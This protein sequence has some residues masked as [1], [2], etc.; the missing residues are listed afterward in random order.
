MPSPM[1]R[2]L[3]SFTVLGCAALA[4][5][6]LAVTPVGATTRPAPARAPAD[7]SPAAGDQSLR[8]F[9]P[10]GGDAGWA[11]TEDLNGAPQG[12]ART[13]NGGK[14][15]QKVTPNGLGK[16]TGD[17]VITGFFALG[18]EHAWVTYGG[19]SNGA[20][21]HIAA[22]TDGG[23]HW[24]V[25]GQ[26]PLTS[27]SYSGYVYDCGLDFVSASVGW[28]Q[29][30]PA[31]VGSEGVALY[32]TTDGGRHWKL[33]SQTGPNGNKAG[34]L[35]WSCDKEIQFSSTTT[36]WAIFGCPNAAP[37]YETT[38][39]G[40]T[41]IKRKVAAPGGTVD[42]GSG[43]TGQPLVSGSRGAVGFTISGQPLKTLVYVTSDGGKSWRPVTPPGASEG[44]VADAITPQSWRLVDG[45]HILATDN[46]GKTWRTITSNVTFDI[47]YAFDYPTPPVVDFASSQVGWIAGTSLWRTTDGGKIWRRLAVPGT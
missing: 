32:R 7:S 12:L 5:L 28:C 24:T 10:A 38:N 46:A 14:T 37:L 16:Q 42:S 17:H 23:R 43:F 40:K 11:W 45:D 44:W 18:A 36:G 31:F 41:W 47:Y 19:I 15:W 29:T 34:S 22:T 35:P 2:R 3:L 26:E 6:T 9:W 30:E 1:A 21:Q 25:V 20:V 39:G 4:G 33:I 13:V 27:V 8:Q